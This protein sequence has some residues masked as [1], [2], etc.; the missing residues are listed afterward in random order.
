M[1]SE[2]TRYTVHMYETQKNTLK[3]I[4]P[5]HLDLRKKVLFKC[6]RDQL[7]NTYTKLI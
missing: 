3:K 2:N 5:F 6:P 7:L 4:N 1:C